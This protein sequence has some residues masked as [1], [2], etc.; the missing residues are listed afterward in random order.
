MGERVGRS[1]RGTRRSRGPR[2]WSWKQVYR[3]GAKG[4]RGAP[5]MAGNAP[6]MEE[7]WVGYG[8]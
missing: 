8:R 3:I 6:E 1:R 7:G 2:A 4:V 5:G